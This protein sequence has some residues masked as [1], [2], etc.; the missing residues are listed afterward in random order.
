MNMS[1]GSDGAFD[2]TE[3]QS[4]GPSNV[5]AAGRAGGA[6]RGVSIRVEA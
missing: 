4:G 3:D 2:L 5:F 1:F 6:W